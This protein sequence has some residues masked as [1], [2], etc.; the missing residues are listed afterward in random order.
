MLNKE[1]DSIEMPIELVGV[2][3]G[4]AVYV[5]DDLMSPRY[6]AGE[7]LFVNP[8]KPVKAGDYCVIQIGKGDD[9][10]GYV[11]QYVSSDE[12][13]MHFRQINPPLDIVFGVGEISAVHRVVG[14]RE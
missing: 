1:Y 5:Y 9:M 11:K 14:M 4:Y 12:E 7:M 6:R 10:I 8:Y 3:G 2:D 13:R